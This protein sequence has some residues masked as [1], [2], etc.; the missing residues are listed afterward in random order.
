MQQHCQYKGRGLPRGV[1]FP[2]TYP[3][4]SGLNYIITII[5]PLDPIEFLEMVKPGKI[6]NYR[7]VREVAYNAPRSEEQG[8]GT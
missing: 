3:F 1:P 5:Y 2:P 8:N 6:V 4:Q 7:P